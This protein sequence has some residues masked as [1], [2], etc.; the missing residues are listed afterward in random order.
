MA[1][2][3][4]FGTNL[5]D[6]A[7]I[8]V[9]DLFYPGGSVLREL[10][11]FSIFAALLGAAVTLVYMIGLIERRNGALPRMGIDSLV[12]VLLYVSGL[13]VMYRLR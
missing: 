10:D 7:L 5:F 11:Q 4:I 6:I 2:S 12:V 9:V 8:F 3:D 1:F 13:V